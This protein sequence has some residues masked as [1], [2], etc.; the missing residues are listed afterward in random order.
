MAAEVSETADSYSIKLTD[1]GTAY[2]LALPKD[3]NG[4][5]SISRSGAAD[6]AKY[7]KEQALEYVPAGE[8]VVTDFVIK[9]FRL[10]DVPDSITYTIPEASDGSSYICYELHYGNNIVNVEW[11]ISTEQVEGLSGKAALLGTNK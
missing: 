9:H 5:F 4:S 6:T 8:K 7:T 1:A 3:E 2:Q 11:N 10:F